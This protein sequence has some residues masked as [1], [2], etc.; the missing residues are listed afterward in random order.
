MKLNTSNH[1]LNTYPKHFELTPY[2]ISVLR[3]IRCDLVAHYNLKQNL[4]QPTTP[5]A[6]NYL[7]HTENNNL[8]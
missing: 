1:V 3:L 4:Y 2:R 5:A 6:V 8:L 7:N